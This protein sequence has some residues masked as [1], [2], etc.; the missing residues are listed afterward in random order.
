[1]KIKIDAVT[2]AMRQPGTISREATRDIIDAG[3]LAVTSILVR[4]FYSRPVRIRSTSLALDP[5][6]WA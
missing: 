2:S 3:Q 6:V 5:L 4:E 1:M